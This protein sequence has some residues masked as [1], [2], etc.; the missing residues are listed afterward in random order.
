MDG[1]GGVGTIYS[2]T[3]ESKRLSAP[4]GCL[5]IQ[6]GRSISHRHVAGMLSGQEGHTTSSLIGQVCHHL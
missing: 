4:E 1:G 3:E 6:V 5:L 2:V